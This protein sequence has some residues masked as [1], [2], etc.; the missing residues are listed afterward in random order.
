[1]VERP[2]Q[3]SAVHAIRNME[4]SPLAPQSRKR[5]R[6]QWLCVFFRVTF[7]LSHFLQLDSIF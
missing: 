4:E 2:E 7:L 5:D 3:S 1:M 6:A